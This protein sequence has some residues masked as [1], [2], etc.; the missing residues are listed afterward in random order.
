MS[1]KKQ[2]EHLGVDQEPGEWRP[3]DW[4]GEEENLSGDSEGWD[5]GSEKSDDEQDMA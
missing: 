5:E 2:V 3:L 4:D 1:F